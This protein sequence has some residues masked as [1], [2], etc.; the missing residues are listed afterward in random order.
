M[1]KIN[2][3]TFLVLFWAFQASLV[4]AQPGSPGGVPGIGDAPVGGGGAGIPLD[5]GA[6]ELLLAGL[7]YLGFTKAKA[8]FKNRK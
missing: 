4:F 7:A 8:W 6:I 1:R 3:M 2:K 5:G